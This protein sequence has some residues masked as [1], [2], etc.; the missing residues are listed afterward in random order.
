M[1]RTVDRAAD[2]GLGDAL[3]VQPSE[4]AKWAMVGLIAVY[5]AA[6]ATMIKEFWRGLVP[7]M[8]CIGLVAGFIVL[9]DLGTGVADRGCRLP[10]AP[11]GRGSSAVLRDA[12]RLGSWVSPE[13][14]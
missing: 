11:G 8:I 4:I 12:V 5:C 7:A 10:S 9:A 6:R 3:S 2:P 1:G 14:S 13:R